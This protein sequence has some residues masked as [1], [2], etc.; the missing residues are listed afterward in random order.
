MHISGG[1]SK[2]NVKLNF[3]TYYKK[4]LL[5]LKKFKKDK[6]YIT[7]KKLCIYLILI[8]ALI[9]I[10]P[11]TCGGSSFGGVLN[12]RKSTNN[13]SEYAFQFEDENYMNVFMNFLKYLQTLKNKCVFSVKH[14]L[15]SLKIV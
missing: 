12:L 8:I 13:A 9:K 11:T 1:N 14:C 15:P 5:I 6:D 3:F 7:F 10:S 2:Q 4:K